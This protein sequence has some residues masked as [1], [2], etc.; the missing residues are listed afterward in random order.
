MHPILFKFPRLTL[1]TYGFFVALAMAL[2]LWLSVK[3][4]RR[5]GLPPQ[6]ALDLLFIV[7][8]SGMFGA[9]LFYVLQ[10]WADFSGDWTASFRLQEGGLVWYGGF[11]TGT[12]CGIIS[13]IRKKQSVLRWADFFAPIAPLGHAVG[14][15]GC[16]FNGCC[17]GRPT[18]SFLGVFFPGDS[19]AR[20]PTQLYESFGLAVIAFVLFKM[21]RQK[22][23]AG[24]IASFY[25][26]FYGLLRFGLELLR[27]DQELFFQLSIPQWI[28]LGLFTIGLVFLR[29]FRASGH[30]NKH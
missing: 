27:A 22:H 24:Q 23:G 13:C 3:R 14:R 21:A 20:H 30:E 16:F 4:S 9:R 18:D 5:E 17:Y 12:F 11:L 2:V 8:V 25:M 19:F 6:E 29:M 26:L 7:F 28:S 1:Y 10:H 15:L